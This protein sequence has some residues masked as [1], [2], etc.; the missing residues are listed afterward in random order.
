MRKRT[1]SAYSESRNLYVAVG[2]KY[3]ANIPFTS[4]VAMPF[5]YIC[6]SLYEKLLKSLKVKY[7]F[8]CSRFEPC[9]RNGVLTIEP[10]LLL[11]KKISF[12]IIIIIN[13]IL[14]VGLK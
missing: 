9:T 12:I 10:K 11:I 5:Q 14:L 7:I 6:R 1:E 3:N 4:S 2:R 13:I 8:P